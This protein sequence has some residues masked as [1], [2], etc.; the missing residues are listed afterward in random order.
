MPDPA[1]TRGAMSGRSAA[2]QGLCRSVMSGSLRM[3]RKLMT[4]L[5][6]QAVA[7]R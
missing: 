3:L 5:A 1:T 6:R 7:I 2:I 4:P